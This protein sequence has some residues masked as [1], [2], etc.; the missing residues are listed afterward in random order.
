MR[1]APHRHSFI[2]SLT[3]CVWVVCWLLVGFLS[4][5]VARRCVGCVFVSIVVALFVRSLRFIRFIRFASFV[6]PVVPC[7]LLL[8]PCPL[9]LVT[10]D[11]QQGCLLSL[12]ALVSPSRRTIDNG[13]LSLHEYTPRTRLTL[14]YFG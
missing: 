10:K 5:L 4:W 6:V 9:P 8:A 2:H 14:R 11:K 1:K 12:F 3:H 13:F 7:F